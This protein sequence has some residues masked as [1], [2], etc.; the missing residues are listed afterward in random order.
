MKSDQELKKTFKV[1]VNK[2][3]ILNIAFLKELR[4]AED[5]IRQTE[6]MEEVILKIF[7]ENSQKNHNILVDLSGLS[8]RGINVPPAKTRRI[9]AR[10]SSQKQVVK[11]AYVGGS[12]L[13][14]TVAGFIL[15]A[16]GRGKN[17]KWFA[18]REKAGKWLKQEKE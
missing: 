14:K 10:L 5:S 12:I 11:V 3:D 13:I 17:M 1:F 6:L 16:A 8:G 18:D 2:N 9:F 4:E 15:Q 7:N